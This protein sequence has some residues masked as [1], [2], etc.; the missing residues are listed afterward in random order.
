MR[1][2]CYNNKDCEQ[3]DVPETTEKC[4]NRNEADRISCG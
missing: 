2:L 4:I 3:K 1:V